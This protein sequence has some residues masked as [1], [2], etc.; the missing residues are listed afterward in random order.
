MVK[1]SLINCKYLTELLPF[2]RF[3]ISFYRDLP[4]VEIHIVEGEHLI[5]NRHVLV[6]ILYYY[7]LMF[8]GGGGCR[9]NFQVF[10]NCNFYI[11]LLSK[12]KLK[13]TTTKNNN[14]DNAFNQ[15]CFIFNSK[16]LKRKNYKKNFKI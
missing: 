7:Q 1:L 12:K 6:P 14:E 15:R 3:P 5:Q 8:M 11:S 16:F 10:F 9:V 13:K 2:Q 4:S